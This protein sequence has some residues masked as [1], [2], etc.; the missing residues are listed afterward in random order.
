[1]KYTW[2][3]SEVNNKIQEKYKAKEDCAHHLGLK[4]IQ[5]LTHIS[6]DTHED[7]KHVNV[8]SRVEMFQLWEDS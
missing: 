3:T 7:T 2:S 8:L 6:D 4:S 1:M 5:Y